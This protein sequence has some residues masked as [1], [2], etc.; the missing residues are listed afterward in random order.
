MPEFE[1]TSDG[2]VRESS[3]RN[4]VAKLRE[5]FPEIDTAALEANLMLQRTYNTLMNSRSPRWAE[6]GITGLRLNVL[7]Q[8]FLAAE[9]RLTMGEIAV[10]LSIGTPNVTQLVDGLEREGFVRRVSG[11]DDKRLVYA[12]LTDLGRD[13]FAAVFPVNAE[14]LKEAWA[15]LSEKEKRQLI[16]L[17][18]R[19][20]LHLLTSINQTDPSGAEVEEDSARMAKEV[21]QRRR[22]RPS[23]FRHA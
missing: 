15:P 14:S 22:R 23:L 21:P 11:D 2:Q 18:A 8:L 4:A 19:L 5:I 6:L 16:Q 12:Q 9:N 17:L 1:V 10:D 3:V 7:R 13:R 20:R